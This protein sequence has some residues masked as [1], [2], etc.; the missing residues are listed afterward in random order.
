M[1]RAGRRRRPTLPAR[2]LLTALLVTLAWAT[3]P[4]G[5]AQDGP[6]GHDA[7]VVAEVRY[8]A[9]DQRST[10]TGRAPL[11]IERFDVALD[12][13]D[14]AR[15]EALVRV[16]ELRSGNALRDFQAR[17]T[18]FDAARHPE[19]RFRLDE[20]VGTLDPSRRGPQPLEL[21]GALTVRDVVRTVRIAATV[22]IDDAHV[23][24]LARF[25]LS[26]EAFEL[27]A[28]RLLTLVV[29]DVVAIEVDAQWPR[30]HDSTTTTR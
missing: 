9:S 4:G 6:A 5:S 29:D 21:V 30:D 14:E 19:V 18:V 16:D 12:A 27:E 2:A 24:V 7:A 26:L 15:L 17:A 23:Q 8:H 25:E 11:R 20:V 3:G 28:P 22:A 13:L 10:W 1:R